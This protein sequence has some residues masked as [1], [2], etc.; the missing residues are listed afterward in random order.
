MPVDGI[1][2]ANTFGYIFVVRGSADCPCHDL[3]PVEFQVGAM[4]FAAA[5]ELYPNFIAEFSAYIC[6]ENLQNVFGIQAKPC[7]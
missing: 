2:K 4:D 5:L 6:K 3:A 1:D 7:Q